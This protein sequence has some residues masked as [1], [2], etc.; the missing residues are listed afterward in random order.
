MNFSYCN[1]V[2][3]TA[4]IEIDRLGNCV[5]RGLD[6]LT[7]RYYLII[8]TD[9]IGNTKILQCGPYADY[10]LSSL[11][12]QYKKIDFQESKLKR[13]IDSFLNNP[14]AEI[15]QA[16]QISIDEVFDEIKNPL[17]LIT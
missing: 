2:T 16:E 6:I 17:E 8:K 15:I 11:S 4:D 13:I 12:I 3:Q 7:N 5:L 14:K 9:D 1:E 10:E